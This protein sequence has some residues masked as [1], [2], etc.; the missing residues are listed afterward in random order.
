MLDYLGCYTK[1]LKYDAVPTLYLPNSAS[2]ILKESIDEAINQEPL[3]TTDLKNIIVCTIPTAQ[4]Q[5]SFTAFEANAGKDSET[6]E[7]APS[8]GLKIQ[9]REHEP[10]EEECIDDTEKY[11]HIT[12]FEQLEQL[13]KD[14][15]ILKREIEALEPAVEKLRE[16][17]IQKQEACKKSS[18]ELSKLVS[19]CNLLH[20]ST[21]SIQEQ[22]NVLSKAF[23]ESQIKILSGKKKIY[24]SNDDMAMGYTIR[25]MSNKR[26]YMYLSKNLKIPLPALSSIK[27]WATLKKTEAGTEIKKE[28]TFEVSD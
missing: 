21:M 23:S 3:A 1:V 24:W 17:L 26:C 2:I 15:L 11:Q 14:N 7:V 13:Q 12:S 28:D 22:K 8:T 6:V 20:T 9:L 16:R 27:R 18:T 4:E 25:H 19:S 5:S 10:V